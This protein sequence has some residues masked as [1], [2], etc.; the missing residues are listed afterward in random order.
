MEQ[1]D[2]A[3]LSAVEATRVEPDPETYGA[4]L[5]LLAR[6]PDVVTRVRTDQR[7]FS[8]VADPMGRRVFLGEN[9]P[10]LRAVDAR[11][12]APLWRRDD[13]RGQ[14]A[15]L[16]VSPDGALLAVVTWAAL[17]GTQDTLT[18][19]DPVTGADRAVVAL[20][21][22]APGA[23]GL[24]G[25]AGWIA[26]DRL[27]LATDQRV[28][29][30]DRA[31]RVVRSVAWQRPVADAGS[32]VVWPDGR[33]SVGA[34]PAGPPVLLDLRRPRAGS[35]RLRDTVWA[36]SPDAT[37]VAAT[38][39]TTT[40]EQLV[41]L[42]GRTLRPASKVWPLTGGAVESVRYSRDGQRIVVAGGER[43]EVRDGRSGAPLLDL[44]GHG[45]GISAAA[46]A[47]RD[48]VWS[49]SRDS[50]AVGFDTTGREGTIATR[51]SPDAPWNG[52]AAGDRVIWTVRNP[53]GLDQVWLRGPGDGRGRRLALT[54]LAGCRCD[55]MSTD[56]TPD[57]TV[58]SVGVSVLDDRWRPRPDRGRVVVWDAA[59]REVRARI[60]TPWPVWAVDSSP[61]G[62][63]LV[64]NGGSG[65]GVV[66]LG[67]QR[68]HV[69]GESW[70]PWTRLGIGTAMAEVAPDGRHALLL[71]GRDALLVDLDTR[72]TLVERRV[73]TDD[74]AALMS[75]AWAPDGRTVAVGS[76]A[77]RFFVLDGHTLATVR[78][79]RAVTSG[80]L[81]DVEVSPD[82]RV[83]ATLGPEGDLTLWDVPSW[84]PFGGPL[85]DDGTNGLLRFMPDSARL[86]AWRNDGVVASVA[87]R[88]ADWVAAACAAA[89]RE[90]T[91][92][93]WAL[94]RP[95]VRQHPV[96]G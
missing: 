17:D 43:L 26:D 41:V 63:R 91:A 65:W 11:T 16:A 89:H 55:P 83:A 6:Q 90:P 84:R 53:V 68:L 81:V 95:G 13:L 85:F 54:G 5:T 77:G 47:G 8:V 38:R 67:T 42:D 79:V 15:A 86:E 31:G 75:A 45:G 72:K 35:R 39:T 7:F 20:D 80:V 92:R 59:H 32:F 22:L 40:G 21:R 4:V 19:L 71:R 28:L 74:T 88:P 56:L 48:R 49:A 69:S 94:L 12:G 2:L 18:L 58:A 78:P 29:V 44:R 24:W 10:V 96:C 61:S 76:A 46:F 93:E 57:G 51:P 14:P 60:D 30:V 9:A 70:A 25:G 66:D 73:E 34:N 37:R 50:T 52:E 1:P 36:V 27:V 3:L 87:T 82:G 62:D 64:V 23:P 33:V